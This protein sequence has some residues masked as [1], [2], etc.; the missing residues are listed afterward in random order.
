MLLFDTVAN[1]LFI[2]ALYAVVAL[3]FSIQWGVLGI[4][5]LAHGMFVVLGAYL[6]LELHDSLGVDPFLAIPLVLLIFFICGVI[7]QFFVI[8]RIMRASLWVTLVLTF[9]LQFLIIGLTL[10]FFTADEQLVTTSYSGDAVTIAGLRLPLSRLG[11]LAVAVVFSLAVALFLRNTRAGLAISATAS[12]RDA[13]RLSGIPV[14]RFYALAFG[15]GI[16]LAGVAGAMLSFTEPFTPNTG[17]SLTLKAFVITIL[18][19]FGSVSGVL[20]GGLLLGLIEAFSA[21]Y[22]GAAYINVISF[23][24]L[25]ALLIFRPQ[26]LMGTVVKE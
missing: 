3:A 2:G 10:L 25:V 6:T 18:G 12:D 4:I 7:L 15:L 24:L 19:G 21:V 1:G 17:V 11:L 8:N 22:I 13:A 5:N 14:A 20:A 26:G 23:V 16:G 9:G